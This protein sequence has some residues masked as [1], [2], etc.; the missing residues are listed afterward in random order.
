MR[1][2]VHHRLDWTM[3]IC[4][5]VAGQQATRYAQD[6]IPHYLMINCM[7]LRLRY[8]RLERT[9]WLHGVEETSVGIIGKR[10]KETHGLEENPMTA[11]LG[12]PLPWPACMISNRTW[13]SEAYIL[14]R[15]QEMS[16]V[17]GWPTLLQLCSCSGTAKP[18]RLISF[19]VHSWAQKYCRT[20]RDLIHSKSKLNGAAHS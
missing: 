1:K 18:A 12:L 20:V 6:F 5:R 7:L 8:N 9:K 16:K 14:N 17:I 11:A 19:L 3:L 10:R 15:T 4:S 13:P 2:K